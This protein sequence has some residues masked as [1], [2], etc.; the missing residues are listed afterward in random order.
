MYH[1][2]PR[3]HKNT[4]ETDARFG[5]ASFENVGKRRVGLLDKNSDSTLNPRS[6]FLFASATDPFSYFY[7]LLLFVS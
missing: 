5:L 6:P 7:F 2:L 4:L 3:T 1:L